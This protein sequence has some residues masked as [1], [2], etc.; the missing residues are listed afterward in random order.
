M[1]TL[2]N[3]G[4]DDT[5]S[6]TARRSIRDDFQFAGQ[7]DPQPFHLSRDAAQNSLF[8]G[9]AA[10]GR[11]VAALTIGLV[12]RAGLDIANGLIGID[13]SLRW[14]RPTRPGD[15]LRVTVDMLEVR[16]SHTRPAGAS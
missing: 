14:P 5:I 11:R 13:V 10:S 7:Y 16:A 1:L 12:V 8:K 2:R 15:V 9:L 3:G 4:I 6:K